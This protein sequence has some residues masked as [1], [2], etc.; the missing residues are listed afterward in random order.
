MKLIVSALL[1]L[2]S[3]VGFTQPPAFPGAQGWGANAT[4]GRGG[5]VIQVSNLN[6]A[7]PGSLREAVNTAGPRTIVF[8]TGGIIEL[9]TE[10][11]ITDPFVYI[12]AQTAPGDGIVLKNF[13]IAVFTHDVIIRG[14][15]IRPGDDLPDQSPDNRD[16]IA[17]Q[18]GSHNVI[19]DHCSFSWA[20]DENLSIAD[21]GVNSITVQWCILS[22]GLLRSIHP[23]GL[24][25]MGA[26]V[27]NGTSHISLHHNLFAHNHGRNPLMHGIDQEFVNNVVYDWGIGSEFHENGDTLRVNIIG[28][29]WKPL[30]YVPE[31]NEFPISVDFTSSTPFHSQ[32]QCQEN[33]SNNG[34]FFTPAQLSTFGADSVLVSSTSLLSS[35]STIPV[36]TAREA[37]DIVLDWAGAL[38]PT[39]DAVDLRVLQQLRDSM[40]GFIDCV[41]SDSI[42]LDSG[43]IL[44]ASDSS[45]TY[46]VL[47][48]PIKYRAEGRRIIISSGTGAGQIRNGTSTTV[49]DPVNEIIEGFIDTD[50]AIVPDASSTFEFFAACENNLGGWPSYQTGTPPTDSDN[51]GMPD[52]WEVSHGLDM[53]DEND[54]NDF[55]L[56]TEGYT[57]L[58]VYLNEF[59]QP[60]TVSAI[61]AA[62]RLKHHIRIRP[63][64]S[65][66]MASFHID[67][68]M[69]DGTLWIYNHWGQGVK[70]IRHVS[71]QKVVFPHIDLP[72]GIYYVH[73][74]E[75]NEMVAVEK[76]AIVK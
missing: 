15:R 70:E 30:T 24:H 20:T 72:S 23:K 63:N 59:F 53:M 52:G 42:F 40:G 64:P 65:S 2:L 4:G 67:K 13:Q 37:F 9:Q 12:A 26:L 74:L 27:T 7:G 31:A 76:W 36:Q 32:I 17:I 51:D 61:Q 43:T 41:G 55:D 14:L 44:S 58:E 19:I 6:D 38:H 54:R 28:N 22:E 33:L 75:K 29:Y 56:S 46:S 5:I 60:H 50:W 71:G 3:S 39:R 11:Q 66:T 49:I 8:R 1:I 62:V 34:L 35:P 10:I 21:N 48:D 68:L 25:S 47:T 45:F 57:N 18:S 16:G 73:L 69:V